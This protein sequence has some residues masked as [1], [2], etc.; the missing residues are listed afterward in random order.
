MKEFV[1][2]Y[3]SAHESGEEREVR[4]IHTFIETNKHA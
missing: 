1:H 2:S 4:P 3:L